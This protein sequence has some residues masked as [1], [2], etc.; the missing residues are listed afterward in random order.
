M[1]PVMQGPA[2][3]TG[4]E[5][6]CPCQRIRQ[7]WI[8]WFPSAL[9]RFRRH[10]LS[11]AA[12]CDV[13]C[14]LQ[15][16]SDSRVC[17]PS[18]QEV[19]SECPGCASLG[20]HSCSGTDCDQTTPALRLRAAA[21]MDEGDHAHFQGRA[22]SWDRS[23]GKNI[24]PPGLRC[25]EPSGLRGDAWV[26]RVS[27][28]TPQRERKRGVPA[29]LR[30]GCKSLCGSKTGAAQSALA[31]FCPCPLFSSLFALVMLSCG[32]RTLPAQTSRW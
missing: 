26:P 6:L 24:G 5:P 31:E 15:C 4:E 10:L 13:C 3:D 16:M 7:N 14:I 1:T 22:A 32:V 18:R 25:C 11:V 17:R 2:N 21:A 28:S 8:S 20:F 23:G 27:N 12:G 29:Y 19:D 30:R 9:E